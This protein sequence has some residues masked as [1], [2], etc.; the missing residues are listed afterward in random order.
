MDC[1][2]L[3]KRQSTINVSLFPR[4]QGSD[5]CSMCTQNGLR[6]LC[7]T[8]VWSAAGGRTARCASVQWRDIWRRPPPIAPSVPLATCS[9][10]WAWASSALSDS[11][12]TSWFSCSSAATRCCGPPSTFCWWIF[13][14]VI[15]W[16][17]CWARRS[18]S[19][20]ALKGDGSS[21][22]VDAC[23]TALPTRC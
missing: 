1:S 8:W 11:S 21:A 19:R 22:T 4:K 17:A 9:W 15:F 2:L 3:S 10:R 20:R 23:G 7:P 12:T 18:A 14:W 13:A 16:F 5:F 6:W